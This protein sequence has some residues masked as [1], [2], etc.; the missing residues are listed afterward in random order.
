MITE[1]IQGRISRFGFTNMI[2]ILFLLFLLPS[3]PT[4]AADPVIGSKPAAAVFVTGAYVTWP[5]DIASTSR[6]DY[7]TDTSYGSNVTNASSGTHHILTITGLSANTT[8][9]FK[10]TSGV[11]ASADYT[12]T[13]YA[14]PTGT[15]RTVGSGKTYSTI[16]ACVN[17]MSAGDTCLVYAGTYNQT[18]SVGTGSAGNYKTI[19]AQEAATVTGFSIG[20]A[21]YSAMKGFHITGGSGI[22]GRT[23]NN[24]LIENNY[25]DGST[26]VCILVSYPYF[27][28]W[29]V[30]R[31]NIL[32]NCQA[33]AQMFSG[34]NDLID[35]NDTS[36]CVDD[37][38]YD[39]GLTNSV[40]RNNN[41]HDYDATSTGNHIDGFQF[42]G[43]NVWPWDS[44]HTGFNYTL[45]EGNT[46]QRCTD[47]TGNCHFFI[48]RNPG[49]SPV[50]T[51]PIIRYN[52]GQ[53]LDGAGILLGGGSTDSIPYGRVYNNTIAL[54]TLNTDNGSVISMWVSNYTNAVMNIAYNSEKPPNYPFSHSTN[55]GLNNYNIAFS[56]GYPGASWNAPY[57]SE[58]TYATLHSKDPL[59]TNYPFSPAIASNSPAVDA[60][61]NLTTVTSGCGTSTLIL[62]DARYFQPGW[63]G[64]QADTLAI[65]P[66]VAGATIAQIS[67]ITYSSN[68][69]TFGSSVSCTNGDKVWLY[70][71]SDGVRVLYGSAPDI[72]AYEYGSSPNPPPRIS[73]PQG[74]EILAP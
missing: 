20:T 25:L 69:V 13:T 7:G 35:G 19:L 49:N 73:P 46:I 52:Y 11:T 72:G 4:F 6:V 47:P 40:Y 36:F 18:V 16:Q 67:N 38:F 17:A 54:E 57:S 3:I 50:T 23:S 74:V 66:T 71:K 55:G 14:N 12:F 62:G 10:V 64:T 15:V 48:L 32:Y 65:G 26:D 44:T 24:I 31:N 63:G 34:N 61:T 28:D 42:D 58:A 43:S 59:F 53:K 9:H 21:A 1:R 51:N 60:G 8:Y 39:G 70:A 33:Q 2:K 27:A 68:T 45:I 56:S 41:C 29:W 5:T 22:T 37:C 30:V